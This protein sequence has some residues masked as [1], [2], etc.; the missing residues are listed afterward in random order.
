[1]DA[2][3]MCCAFKSFM[4]VP[5]RKKFQMSNIVVEKGKKKNKALTVMTFFFASTLVFPEK[6]TGNEILSGLQPAN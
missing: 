3:Q 5:R 2:K 4:R 6:Q 1:M